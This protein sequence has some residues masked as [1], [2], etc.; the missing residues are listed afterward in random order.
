MKET[1]E[2]MLINWGNWH[3]GGGYLSSPRISIIGR[4]ILEGAGA[5][6]STVLT[7]PHMSQSVEITEQ[8][9]LQMP[10]TLQRVCKHRYIGNEPDQLAAKK[11][12]CT[13]REYEQRINHAVE[14]L[15]N[16]LTEY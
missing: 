11:L 5:S 4:C 7:E 6:H 10:K 1:A 12:K 15:A 8:C 9:V 13:I 14:I 3:R 2:V 16:Y